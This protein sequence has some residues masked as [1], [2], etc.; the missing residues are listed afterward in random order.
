MLPM[1][2]E[3]DFHMKITSKLIPL[4]HNMGLLVWERIFE[5]PVGGRSPF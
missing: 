3:D 4:S 1:T 2:G 5:P